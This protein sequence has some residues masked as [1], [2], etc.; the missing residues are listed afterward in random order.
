MEFQERLQG[1]WELAQS[2]GWT[3]KFVTL[4]WRDW[5]SHTR[6]NL[7]LAHLVQSLRRKYGY[8]EYAK[9]PE[10]TKRGVI[11][12]HLAMVMPY[13]H[14]TVLSR[15][16]EA[17]TRGTS[18]VVDIRAAKGVY[19]L[20]NELAKYLTKGPAGKVTY[21]RRFPVAKEI[22]VESGPC[23]ACGG[24]EHT[25][26]FIPAAEAETNFAYE[27]EGR[28]LGEPVTPMGV[29]RRCGCWPVPTYLGL[30]GSDV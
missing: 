9:V 21:S 15:M 5:V 26:Q 10:R 3:L 27:T 1:A 29:L 18:Y 11:H 28:R 25:F 30:E 23:D 20:R 13:V 16:W 17:H 7:D 6:V 4:T 22:K 14:Q 19:M 8:C 2:E 24:K 12:L